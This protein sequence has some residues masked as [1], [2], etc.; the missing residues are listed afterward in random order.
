MDAPVRGSSV[1][2]SSGND[3]LSGLTTGT[4]DIRSCSYR[5]AVYVVHVERA[6]CERTGI[7]AC[8]GPACG[9]PLGVLDPGRSP[10]HLSS[11]GRGSEEGGEGCDESDRERR[12]GQHDGGT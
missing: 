5:V 8:D 4:E 7:V 11:D 3:V 12:A 9:E 6:S 10:G 1:G 2:Q